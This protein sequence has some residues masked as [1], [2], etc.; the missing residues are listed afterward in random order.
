MTIDQ[1]LQTMSQNKSSHTY[2]VYHKHFVTAIK[3]KLTQVYCLEFF[4]THKDYISNAQKHF[5]FKSTYKDI[6]KI[7]FWLSHFSI[8]FLFPPFP[9]GYI[10]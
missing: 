3:S 4:L 2:V 1:N 7:L 6:V 10:Y 9:K 8:S 5:F